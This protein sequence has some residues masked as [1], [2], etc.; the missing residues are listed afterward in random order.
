MK[1]TLPLR[2]L[3]LWLCF[4][5]LGLPAVTPL[6]A[7]STWIGASAG[8]WGVATNWSPNGV[9]NAVNA[10]A[11]FNTNV[12]V[13]VTNTGAGGNFPYTFGTL[14]TTGVSGNVVVGNTSYSTEELTAQTSAG[15]PVISINSAATLWF[16]FVLNGTQGFNKTGGGTLTF[17][18]NSETQ[19][20]T[21]AIVIS[22]G[23]LGLNVDANLGN[24]NNGI[25]FSNN[26]ELQ[27]NPT[28]LAPLTLASSRTVTLSCPAA[29]LDVSGTNWLAIPG[30]INESPPGSGL[31]KTDSGTLVLSGTNTYTGATTIS[32]GTL[33]I[34]GAGQ[35]GGG[36]Y[37][38][39]IANSGSF[40]YTSSAT[41]LFSGVI[42]GSGS[43]TQ[44]G[45][46]TL[47]LNNANT[48]AGGT[49]IGSGTL[50]LGAAGSISSSTNISLAAGALYDVSAINSYS[51]GGSPTLTASGS[52]LSATIKGAP[53]GTVNLGTRPITLNFDGT[54]PALTLSQGTL[55][56]GGQT[57]TVNTPQPL[58]NGIYT[59]L[60]QTT[61]SITHSGSYG[62]AGTAGT[63]T[64]TVSGGSVQ[65]T[66]TGSSTPADFTRLRLYWETNWLIGNP[67]AATLNSWAVT[68]SNYWNT[69]NT[70]AS[71]TS[72]WSNL[73]LGSD[74]AYMTSTFG[75]L[76]AMALAWAAPGCPLQGN[77]ALASAITN[78]MDWMCAHVY[79]TTA[80]EYFNWWDWQI[81]S[82]Q[83]L[84][85]VV[86]LMYPVL[87][88][89]QITSYNN[90]VDHFNPPNYGWMT[91]A[92]LTD[93][94][95]GMIIRA[96]NG[97]NSGLM[98]YAQTNLSPVFPYVTNSDGFYRDGSFVFHT[99][100]PYTEGYGAT[101]LGDVGQLV[102]LLNG[103]TWQI[104]DPNLTNVFN[105]V[106][107]SFEPVCYYGESMAMVGGRGI[108]RGPAGSG[109]PWNVV[110]V[111]QFAP[112]ATAAAIASWVGS[113][114]LPPSQY[115]F[116]SMDCAVA[117]RSNFCVALRMSSS[118]IAN[119]ESFSGENLHGW[120]TGDGM[121]YLYLGNPD[122]Q[123]TSD[124]W[125]TIDAYHMPGTTE[126]EFTRTNA[127]NS[128]YGAGST[129]GQTWV[130][131]AQVA[132]S[133]G[134][135]GMSVAAYGTTLTA[136]KSW[137]M[138]D[139]EIVCLGAAITC[140][141]GFEVD[142]T[143]ENRR[144]GL[145][146]TNNFT[147]N[148][149]VNPPV[150]GWSSNLTSASWCA[151]DGVAG[152]YF[153]GG[154]TNLRA[155]FVANNGAWSDLNNGYAIAS[156]TNV[157]TDDYLTLWFNHGINPTNSTYA[158]VELPNF[159][160]SGMAAYAANPDLVVLTNTATVQAAAKPALG[161]V[162]AN[163]W[164]DG[165]N[166]AGLI[167]VNKKA[168][169]VTSGNMFQIAVG[170]ADPTQTNRSTI[171][172]TLNRSA[173]ATISADPG[174][175]VVQLSP[176][177]VLS[178]NVNGSLGKTYQ[179]VFSSPSNSVTWDAN[180]GAAGTHP[181]DGSGTWN[182]SNTNWWNGGADVA[183]ND[184]NPLTA[185]F[186]TGGTAGTVTVAGAH[187]N[188]WL[189]F[190][191]AGSGT[192]SLSGTGS[193]TLSN[194]I[195]ANTPA[196]VN[197]PLILPVS[198]TWTVASN[199]T[200]SLGGAVT[201]G[202]GASLWLTG[203]GTVALN[204]GN[205]ELPPNATVAFA[206]NA[207]LSLGGNRQSLTNLVAGNGT[208]G[209]VRN[210]NLTVTAAGGYNPFGTLTTSS[211][212]DLSGLS[213][214]TYS[215]ASQSFTVQGTAATGG[216][217][218]LNLAG[219]GGSN[220]IT[221]ANVYV[222]NGGGTS[223]PTG[224]LYLGQTNV[225]NTGNFQLGAYRGSGNVYFES[226]LANSNVT[227]RGVAGGTNRL[228]TMSI[229]WNQSGAVQNQ[230]MNLGAANVDALIGTLNLLYTYQPEEASTATLSFGN[231]TFD[232]TT[233]N[234]FYLAS[235]NSGASTATANFNQTGGLAKIQTLNMGYNSIPTT[236]TAQFNPNYTLA[237]GATLAAQTIT[238][239]AGTPYYAASV[240]NLNLN[241]GTVS[242]Y[243][244]NT[245]LTFSGADG[246][247]G[248]V[249]NLVLGAGTTSTLNAGNGRTITVQST[250]PISGSGNLTKAGAGWLVLAGTNSYT[251]GTLVS[252]GTMLVNGVL[253]AS[254]ATVGY[255]ATLGG[256]GSISGTVTVQSGGVLLAGNTNQTGTLTIGTL[257]L[258][259]SAGAMTTNRFS[260]AAGGRM[261]VG[262]LSISGKS[263]ISLA[264]SSLPLGTNTLMSYSGAIGGAGFGGLALASSP[265]VPT[266][267]G[268]YLRN[269]GSAIQ[270]VVAPLIV[271]TLNKAVSQ[272]SGV[273]GLS[274]S[275]SSGQ[276][277]EVL[278][279]TNLSLP[280]TNWQ[281]L[282]NGYFGTGVVD[283]T[284]SAATNLL[285]F[286]R[287]KS[288]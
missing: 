196:N 171:S 62:L 188:T 81:G 217:F 176:Q 73:P 182:S 6:A 177:I 46:G 118:R 114:C 186:G 119:Y 74:S 181:Q 141:G 38:G 204:G 29:N 69:L 155:A 135:S 91:G 261:A 13:E 203:G 224:N 236:G 248:G 229:G 145:S 258:G 198:Q 267:A 106:F 70:N 104:T 257:T 52:T 154:A 212:L 245:D 50:T 168:S 76:Q 89:A 284:D 130:G 256:A 246:T 151:L 247:S 252:A 273:I 189:L 33:T 147:V 14:A 134:A 112:P 16:Y 228:G 3:P 79:T 108:D 96:I 148:G 288:P 191:P 253:Q 21:G 166:T 36:A 277:Y 251:G 161:V 51:L 242:N 55:Q 170:V 169:V 34:G 143:V 138:L 131:G 185:N 254:P 128:G 286:Y 193:L 173:A 95:K 37:A 227:F 53:G 116:A 271:P 15:I 237:S 61:G 98:Y 68:A 218:T 30:V 249:L 86:V 202:S 47:T 192:Y 265:A 281:S 156:P 287:I 90:S 60:T 260:V 250:A 84:N 103:S 268:A 125:P 22:G 122:T 190:S 269:T 113:L 102:I 220:S 140:G 255:G 9:P 78:A 214:F 17:R 87:T 230:T 142:T 49:I 175:T 233:L 120:F 167:T 263:L 110:A 39:A 240:R 44:A 165:T 100:Q 92:N 63:G 146:P 42:S 121:M 24:P 213:A 164:A 205:N 178:V 32:G 99:V 31:Q 183:W 283:F 209:A 124:Y 97:Q 279:S 226:G 219:A 275:G 117:W 208:T 239:A 2:R 139:N 274:F 222:G 199:Q 57:F 65:M 19:P 43:L 83:D 132:N 35:L 238:A 216:S 77:P 163:F 45:T 187:T 241:G 285:K 7:Q 94:C 72:L 184:A 126:A 101:L 264:E 25:V 157:Y 8:Q 278:A 210:G 136:K 270:L 1:G 243:D 280:L 276:S 133:Y 201:L 152:Y 107:Q 272:N 153:P 59:I 58:A 111:E 93:Q 54:N 259:D 282:T 109:T 48:Y 67:S 11:N 197:V 137:F 262:N 71:R 174:V 20:Y 28:T 66:I 162:A 194:G 115:Q 195:M 127:A 123:Y 56:L 41:Q 160:A 215:N 158:Y 234:L 235:G 232:I 149:A 12:T 150:M 200:V 80:S 172:V 225:F 159:T 64:I 207:M 85:N 5:L 75:Q 180:P 88:P 179:A 18:Y 40:N 10:A 4:L 206:G 211:M 231:G 105:W 223:L 27:F 26:A 144:L 82:M 244:A 221:A 129:T 23:V 266:G